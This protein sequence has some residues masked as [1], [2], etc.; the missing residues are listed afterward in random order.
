MAKVRYCV[1]C[2]KPVT[3]KK[4]VNWIWMILLF[5]VYILVYLFKSKTCPICKS[6]I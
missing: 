6:K 4:E 5:P 2:Q 3:P 1:Y